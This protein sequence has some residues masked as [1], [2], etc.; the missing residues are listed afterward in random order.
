VVLGEM[1]ELGAASPELHRAAGEEAARA[2]L[3]ELVAVGGTNARAVAE[4]ALQA[5]MP[6]SRVH[7]VENSTAAGD[8]AS[9]LVRSGDVVLV[10]GSRGIRTEAVVERLKAEF[11]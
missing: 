5:G 2:N 4:G 9:T 10:K 7:Y 1:L 8:L 3:S 11:A 6:A